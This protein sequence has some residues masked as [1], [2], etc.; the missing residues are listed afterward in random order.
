MLHYGN[1][2]MRRKH[3]GLILLAVIILLQIIVLLSL[4]AL[5]NAQLFSKTAQR[6]WQN[7][8]SSLTTDTILKQVEEKIIL[9]T[10]HC[11]I[12]VLPINDW[13][14]MPINWW[15]TVA[16]SE[17]FNGLN[18]YYLVEFLGQVPCA[19]SQG[20]TAMQIG[21]Y[22]VTL[23][24]PSEPTQMVQVTLAKKENSGLL[25]TEKKYF[26]TP[27]RQMWRRII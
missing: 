2:L 25:C 15:Q 3:N 16:C 14:K 11:K 13:I 10:P 1:N 24:Y 7:L 21:Y 17:Q 6:A 12:T 27:G 22:R 23:F 9:S 19:I 8:S 5:N 20:D 26:V 18:Y 4:Y